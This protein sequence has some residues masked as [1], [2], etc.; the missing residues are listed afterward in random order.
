M[1]FNSDLYGS[2]ALSNN[3]LPAF[4]RDAVYFCVVLYS[5][6]RRNLENASNVSIFYYSVNSSK[7]STALFFY[8]LILTQRQYMKIFLYPVLTKQ[9]RNMELAVLL[10]V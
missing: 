8:F 5:D 7:A 3:N 1:L 6:R 4:T 2:T 10:Y 9:S